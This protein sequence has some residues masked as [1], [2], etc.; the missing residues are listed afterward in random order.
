MLDGAIVLPMQDCTRSYGGAVRPLRIE[1]LTPAIFEAEAGEA[2]RPPAALAP[3]TDGL[4]TL[5]ALG[6]RTLVDIKRS[7]LSPRSLAVLAMRGR[8]RS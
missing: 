8:R 1:R 7:L 6:D 2:L 5:A 3:F 4:H